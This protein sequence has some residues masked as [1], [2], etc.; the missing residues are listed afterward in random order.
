MDRDPTRDLQTKIQAADMNSR[1]W[2]F[3]KAGGCS[4]L[5]EQGNIQNL[6]FL[7][8]TWLMHLTLWESSQ[9][10][11][12]TERS[13]SPLP[14]AGWLDV[15]LYISFWLQETVSCN[16]FVSTRKFIIRILTLCIQGKEIPHSSQVNNSSLIKNQTLQH[17]QPP[18]CNLGQAKNRI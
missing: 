1:I 10:S 4:L 5:A 9:L 14:G 17:L 16:C 2:I 15:L 18:V 12:L 3:Q 13:A 8:V 6:F 11:T 7:S